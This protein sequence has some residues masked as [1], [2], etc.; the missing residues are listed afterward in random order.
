MCVVVDSM[1]CAAYKN[2]VP[3]LIAR[4]LQFFLQDFAQNG[5]TAKQC[6][7]F[8]CLTDKRGPDALVSFY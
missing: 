6:V 2:L 5:R 3:Y 4:D 7:F 1:D 8:F